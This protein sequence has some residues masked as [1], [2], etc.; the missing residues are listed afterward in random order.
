MLRYL[1]HKADVLFEASGASFREA[2]E[3]A[4]R[5][6]FETIADAKKVK[7]TK[8]IVV[9]QSAK[10]LDELLVFT[11]SD[12]L[13]QGDVHELFFARFKVKKFGKKGDVFFVEG[14]AEGAPMTP[15]LGR[16]SVK[17]VTLHESRV[18]EKDGK[19][20]ARVLLDV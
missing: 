5:A 6:L 10:K 20:T 16:T 12:L 8:K 13:T 7:A 4:A 9:K 15:R 2:L 11:L 17:A 14:T 18:V 3:E 19:W 1:E